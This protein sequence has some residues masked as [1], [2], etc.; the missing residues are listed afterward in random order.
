M[1]V[2]AVGRGDASVVPLD[3]PLEGDIPVSHSKSPPGLLEHATRRRL[4]KRAVPKRPNPLER[5]EKKEKG[6]K[7]KRIRLVFEDRR[8]QAND[9]DREGGMQ[10]ARP[11]AVLAWPAFSA[12]R[13]GLHGLCYLYRPFDAVSAA[14]ML[15]S[16]GGLGFVASHRPSFDPVVGSG[17]PSPARR[18]LLLLAAIYIILSLCPVSQSHFHRRPICL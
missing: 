8:A 12:R 15:N 2:D 14:Q 16:R 1:A 17:H 3:F 10:A 13:I 7:E 6:K 9:E 4:A 18:S 5:G 11:T